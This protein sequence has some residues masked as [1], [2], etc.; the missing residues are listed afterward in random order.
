MSELP[1]GFILA[2]QPSGGPELPAGF[3]LEGA[4]PKKKPFTL[5]DTWPAQ[6]AK[7]LF[8]AATLPGDVYQGKAAVPQSA[9]MGEENTANIG[10]VLELSGLGPTVPRVGA[11]I[12]ATKAGA[13]PTLEQLESAARSGYTAPA[14]AE[15]QIKPEAVKNFG[16]IVSGDLE[17]KGINAEL[18]PKTFSVLRKLGDPPEGSYA[19]A[20]NF[21][22]LRR[23]LGNAARDFTNPT[24]QKAA[25]QAIKH[26]DNYLAEL[27]AQDLIQGDA[28]A[29]AR[30]LS[31]AR[32]N[33]AA[34]RRS[35]TVT[36]AL[37]TADGNAAAA[38]SGQNIGNAIRQRFNSILKSDRASSGFKPDEIA[39]MERVRDGTLTGNAT[40]FA[41]NL[42]G[43][44][45]GLGAVIT[46]GIGGAA[47]APWG[48]F[49]AALPAVG[50]GLKKISDMSVRRQAQL[51]DEMVRANSPLAQSA[52]PAPYV[53]G[54]MT[55][56]TA[57]MLLS[58][59]V[60]QPQ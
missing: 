27:P 7:G 1:P 28:Q 23:T 32:G 2:D 31:D 24:E 53:P 20:S 8:S 51:L 44:G 39:Q 59:A 21:D 10:R 18:A 55:R 56:A 42:L 49:G 3:V 37:E 15:L 16:A 26:L 9:N 5:G 36:D 47:T 30:I 4:A 43:G 19:T 38:N 46:A 60:P 57:R 52:L 54:E 6:V 41:G 35:S 33:Y 29:A 13:A 48:G 34:A 11:T 12:A 17:Q 40:R 50:Y 45:G 14:V 58:G 22:T 25:S